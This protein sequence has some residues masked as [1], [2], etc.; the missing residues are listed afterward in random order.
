MGLNIM[1]YRASMIE[2]TL[3]IRARPGGGTELVCC[4]TLRDGF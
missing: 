3:D 1:Q 4:F 2:A